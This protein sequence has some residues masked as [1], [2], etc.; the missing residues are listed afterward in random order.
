[1]APGVCLETPIEGDD[2]EVSVEP[3]LRG[4]EE[5]TGAGKGV[6]RAELLPAGEMLL[7]L[8]GERN[9]RSPLALRTWVTRPKAGLR[10]FGSADP[11]SPITP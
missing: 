2:V 7:E 5:V 4:R 10:R 11:S 3:V 1:M 8:G 9:E 6:R